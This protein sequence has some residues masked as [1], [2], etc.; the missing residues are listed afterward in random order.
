MSTTIGWFCYQA[1][2]RPGFDN[3]ITG[4][5]ERLLMIIHEII[6]RDF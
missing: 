1:T 6:I 5:A 4:H 3:L 2:R